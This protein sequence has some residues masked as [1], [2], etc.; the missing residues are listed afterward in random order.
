M[1][2]GL[3]ALLLIGAF[4]AL[5]GAGGLIVYRLFRAIS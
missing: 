3:Y 4:F 2:E 1:L 5:A